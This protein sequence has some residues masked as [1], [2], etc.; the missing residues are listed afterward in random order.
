[1]F[2]VRIKHIY[3]KV[4]QNAEFAVVFLFLVTEV[5]VVGVNIYISFN[6]IF[7]VLFL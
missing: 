4:E 7:L 3:K 6:E 5:R 1:M 2:I